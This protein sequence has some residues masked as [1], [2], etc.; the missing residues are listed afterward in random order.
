MSRALKFSGFLGLAVQMLWGMGNVAMII[1]SGGNPPP[2][3]IVGAHAHFGVLGILAIVVGFAVDYYQPQG[4]QRT[5]AT[6]GYILG[7]WL[8]P[9]TLLAQFVTG[10]HMLGLLEFVWGILLLLAMAVMAVQAWTKPQ[11]A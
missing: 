5:L 2:Q 1:S 4:W 11:G 3:S 9:G 10:N 8:L 7:Q 6:W